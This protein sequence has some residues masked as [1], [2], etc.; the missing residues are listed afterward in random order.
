MGLSPKEYD[1]LNYSIVVLYSYFFNDL[2]PLTLAMRP[3]NLNSFCHHWTQATPVPRGLPSVVVCVCMW[4]TDMHTHTRYICPGK[5]WCGR[6]NDHL[7]M[8][9]LKWGDQE[10]LLPAFNVRLHFLK[11]RNFILFTIKAPGSDKHDFQDT[12]SHQKSSN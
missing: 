1:L 3:T 11:Y 5:G 12:T 9:G 7:G 2:W 6:R 4:S 10:V 8:W